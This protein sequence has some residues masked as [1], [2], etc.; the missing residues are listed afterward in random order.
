MAKKYS[1]PIMTI[2]EDLLDVILA[3]QQGEGTDLVDID[4]LFKG[5]DF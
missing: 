4:K 1:A 5:G 2:Q 3:S